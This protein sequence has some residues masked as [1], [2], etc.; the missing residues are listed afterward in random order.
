MEAKTT[1]KNNQNL[2]DL[3]LQ[4]TGGMSRLFELAVLNGM[5]ITDAINAG[6]VLNTQINVDNSDILDYY[7]QNSIVPATGNVSLLELS[8]LE[9]IDYWA[10]GVD[11]IVI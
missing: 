4:S 9:G 7:L 5:G 3:C 1:V 8:I 6:G 2:L 10:I 11:F